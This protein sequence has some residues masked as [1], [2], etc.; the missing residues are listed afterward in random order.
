MVTSVTGYTAEKSAEIEN[1]T[2]VSAGYSEDSIYLQT[3]EG[4]QI[5]LGSV[6]NRPRRVI[7]PALVTVGSFDQTAED[8]IVPIWNKVDGIPNSVLPDPASP[9]IATTN[10]VDWSP[11]GIYLAVGENLSPGVVVYKRSGDV[12]T[13]L[14]DPTSL[15]SGG[16]RGV[17]WSP[18]GQH[19][20]CATGS[21]PYITIYKRSGDLL[22]KLSDPSSLPLTPGMSVSWSPDGKMLVVTGSTGSSPPLLIYSRVGDVFTKLSDPSTLPPNNTIYAAAW[23]SNGRYLALGLFST[24]YIFVYKRSGN[25]FTKLAIPDGASGDLYAQVKSLG[26]SPNGKYLTVTTQS[27]TFVTYVRSGDT[28]TQI[29]GPVLLPIGDPLC[30]DWSPDGQFLCCASTLT[31]APDVYTFEDEAFIQ[32]VGTEPIPLVSQYSALAWSP[33]G[34]YLAATTSS[35][36]PF[37]RIYKT[38]FGPRLGAVVPMSS[39]D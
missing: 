6:S 36:S 19:L 33:D 4:T 9:P 3:K 8:V 26:W 35:T 1:E 18:D 37:V 2:I 12:F 31:G 22:T 21:A 7:E 30:V 39:I 34:V 16:V 29:P 15:P 13:K 24:P 27:N 20:A 28:F 17:S 10:T 32:I 5:E 14:A 25:T 11:D 23:S 38:S